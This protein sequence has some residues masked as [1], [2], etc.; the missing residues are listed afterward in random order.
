MKLNLIDAEKPGLKE[1]KAKE[2]ASLYIPMVEMLEKMEPQF[3]ELMDYGEIDED[4]IKRAKRF[5][6]DIRRVVTN[7]D[8]ARVAAKA[9][10]LRAGNAIQGAF[11]TL[12]YAVESKTEKLLAIE[13]HFEKLEDERVEKI[14]I[15]REKELM[16]YGTVQIP[17]GLGEMDTLVYGHFLTGV[18]TTYEA[19]KESERKAKEEKLEEKRISDLHNE[20]HIFLQANDLFRFGKW[21]STYFGA[22]EIDRW[23]EIIN[24]LEKSKKSWQDDQVK[25][26]AENERLKKQV[27]L[28]RK[29]REVEAEKERKIRDGILKKEREERGKIEAKLRE[30]EL[31]EQKA[32]EAEEARVEAELSKGDDE[33]LA[34]LIHDLTSIASKYSFKSDKNKKMFL[35][36]KQAIKEF[37][38]LITNDGRKM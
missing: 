8:K 15:E 5:R 25:I 4:L 16:Q 11:N 29:K 21:E 12:K 26:K 27:E 3:N 37:L 19:K 36:V 24:V 2:I 33:K 22:I 13:K 18:K 14:R 38:K 32:K 35:S 34:D 10:Y 6:L 9:E 23:E 31:N 20:R 17:F 1:N 7:A 28:D 30:K